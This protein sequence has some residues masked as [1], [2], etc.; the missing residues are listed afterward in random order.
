MQ[1][2][3]ATTG[4]TGIPCLTISCFHLSVVYALV[5][6]YIYYS[7]CLLGSP[8]PSGRT[9]TTC[10]VMRSHEIAGSE[11]GRR[12]GLCRWRTQSLLALLLVIVDQAGSL[13]NET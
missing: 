3:V 9:S 2:G 4:C 6:F 13:S 5:L 7:L 10:M 1:I 8:L 11:L 12:N